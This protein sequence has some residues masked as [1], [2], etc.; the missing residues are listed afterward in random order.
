MAAKK[1]S[2]TSESVKKEKVAASGD[3]VV[4]KDVKKTSKVNDASV[5]DKPSNDAAVNEIT[6]RVPQGG[7]SIRS[8]NLTP[9]K[10]VAGQA[11]NWL[12]VDPTAPT[13]VDISLIKV[14]FSTQSTATEQ[15]FER[16]VL[17]VNLL[18]NPAENG[19]WR[20]VMNGVSADPQYSDVDHDVA[21]VI[22]DQGHTLITQ[23]QVIGDTQ[24]TIQFGF[25]ASFTDAVSGVVTIYESKDP[26]ITPGRP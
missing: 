14:S 9:S 2:K 26:G 18:Q 6:V 20:F 16:A 8:F 4:K 23:V 13:P 19:H 5:N 17:I 21:V 1:K 25:V 24:E 10:P 15:D 7:Q 3:K 12:L 11:A 22:A